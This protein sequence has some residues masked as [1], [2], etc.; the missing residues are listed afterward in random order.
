MQSEPEPPTDRKAPIQLWRFARMFF[1]NLHL[2]WGNPR[3]VAAM[4]FLSRGLQ[5]LLASWLRV[6]EALMRHMLL[7]EAAAFAPSTGTANPSFSRRRP[8]E[9]TL[10]HF[11]ADK[12]EDWRV[13]FSAVPSSPARGGSAERSEAKGEIARFASP[14]S[15]WPL[16]LR[17]EAIVRVFNDPAPDARRLARGLQARPERAEAL[18][19][20]PPEFQH[21]VDHADA[22]TQAALEARPRRPDSS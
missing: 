9:R 10:H 4:P 11:D 1:C 5:A 22:I 18:L 14:R 16:A 21:R 2:A 8:R 13:S 6:G 7:I 20:T 17:Y 19:A 12:P 3:D 15:A